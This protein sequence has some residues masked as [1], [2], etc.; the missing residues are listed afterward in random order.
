MGAPRGKIPILE[1]K[2]RER[3]SDGHQGWRQGS[4]GQAQADDGGRDEGRTDRRVLQRQKDRALRAAGRVYADLLGQASAWF[5]RK[6]SGT[7]SQGRRRR[8][9]SLGQ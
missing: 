8:C 4:V 5:R 1:I 9:L 6:G 2:G 3:K 7:A